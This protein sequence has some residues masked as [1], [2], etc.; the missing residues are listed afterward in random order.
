MVRKAWTTKQRFSKKR[1]ERPR[2]RKGSRPFCVQEHRSILHLYLMPSDNLLHKI[3][4]STLRIFRLVDQ[5]MFEEAFRELD[6]AANELRAEDTGGWLAWSCMATKAL[7]H[8]IAGDSELALEAYRRAQRL[9]PPPWE[10][11]QHQEQ[12]ALA[13][14]ALNRPFSE[15]LE[16]IETGLSVSQ[17]CPP[18]ASLGLLRTYANIA[19]ANGTTVPLQWQQLYRQACIGRGVTPRPFPHDDARAFTEAIAKTALGSS[20]LY[21][22]SR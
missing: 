16:A 13:L 3:G 2:V 9:G 22:D 6:A 8:K 5:G 12:I 1:S 14:N 19:L 21:F 17:S 7:I 20:S 4:E 18:S 11:I 15:V 10:F